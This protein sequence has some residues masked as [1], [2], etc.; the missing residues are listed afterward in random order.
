MAKLGKKH[1]AWIEITP[2]HNPQ[3][4]RVFWNVTHDLRALAMSAMR[5][6]ALTHRGQVWGLSGAWGKPEAGP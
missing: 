1:K 2:L 6:T 4:Y 3:Y 5:G